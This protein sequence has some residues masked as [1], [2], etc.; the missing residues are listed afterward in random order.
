MLQRLSNEDVHTST[1]FIGFIGISF[2]N[3]AMDDG[4][5]D[6]TLLAKWLTPSINLTH[7]SSNSSISSY[8]FSTNAISF[9]SIAYSIYLIWIAYF[10]QNL[11]LINSFYKESPKRFFLSSKKS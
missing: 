11:G 6:I 7:E 3:G 8:E 5:A 1:L 2:D 10:F 9:I 4:I